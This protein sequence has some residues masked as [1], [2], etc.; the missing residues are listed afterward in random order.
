VPDLRAEEGPR[1]R[2]VDR[3]RDAPT[4]EVLVERAREG[5]RHALEGVLRA[6]R[7][8]V[9]NLAIR[10]LRDPHDAEDATQEILVRVMT[11]LS[12]FRG[13]AAFSTWVYRVAANLLFSRRQ[14]ACEAQSLG[15]RAF[16]D[17]LAA[18]PF[19]D[20]PSG[21][22]A[23]LLEEEVKLGCTS[24]MLLCLDRPHRLAFVLGEVF[25]L[26]STQAAYILDVTPAAY[27]QR[28]AR[29]RARIRRFM[30]GNCGLVN[31]SNTCRC[32]RRIGGA[33]GRG[34]VDP[35][36]PVFAGHPRRPAVRRGLVEMERL[37][38]A[39]VI[40]R[41][42]PDYRAPERV[43]A[44]VTRILDGPGLP[45]IAGRAA[46]ATGVSPPRRRP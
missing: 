23:T 9:Y 8:D 29:S 39:A 38:A 3:G 28:L 37:H 41:S 16:A 46:P 26:S 12:T 20:P 5:D 24:A 2:H 44:E 11:R 10:V 43:V 21:V 22:D 15:F 6:I 33:I 13:E 19:G 40:F 25:E 34:R 35:D 1:A 18:G 7:D 4:I 14:S 42:H 32:A 36:A 31:P 45:V 17:D 27:R 30:E